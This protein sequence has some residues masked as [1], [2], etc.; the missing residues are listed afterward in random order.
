RALRS[1]ASR[2][3]GE[4]TAAGECRRHGASR[5]RKV[6]SRKAAEN[7]TTP[8]LCLWAVRH[9]LRRR[10]ALLAVS[11]R[12]LIKGG[13]EILKPFRML[14]LVDYV[15]MAKPMS[16]ALAAAV[17]RLPGT[18]TPHGLLTWCVIATVILFLLTWVA[19]LASNLASMH[20]GQRLVYDLAAE[21]FG[22]LQRLS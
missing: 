19:S 20:F 22:H 11:A 6:M 1:M 21:L 18:A 17:D 4:P 14:V 2:A 10:L 8:T 15:L 5:G 12:M 9:A 13:L 16:P 3:S 7:T